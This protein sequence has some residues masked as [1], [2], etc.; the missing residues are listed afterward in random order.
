MVFSLLKDLGLIVALLRPGRTSCGGVGL[1]RNG[2][3]ESQGL[4]G[5]CL[6]PLIV[7]SVGTGLAAGAEEA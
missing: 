2:R 4:W 1:A 7:L 6:I 5:A 3:F